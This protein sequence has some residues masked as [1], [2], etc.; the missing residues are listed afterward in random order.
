MTYYMLNCLLIDNF[1]DEGFFVRNSGLGVIMNNKPM[2]MELEHFRL[3]EEKLRV[4]EI[5]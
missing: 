5:I 2:K 4:L 3:V 1:G